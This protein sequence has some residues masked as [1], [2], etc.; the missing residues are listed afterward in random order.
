MK[1]ILLSAFVL[2]AAVGI[3]NNALAADD[4]III[5]S[6]DLTLQTDADG[7][8]YANIGDTIRI[9]VDADNTDNVINGD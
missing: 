1:K 7:N 3:G 2:L 4:S 8:S 6:V 9:E 5:N